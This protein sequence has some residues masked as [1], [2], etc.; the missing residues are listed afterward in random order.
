MRP[1]IP[2]RRKYLEN[3]F[4]NTGHSIFRTSPLLREDAGLYKK[5]VELIDK[6]WGS[7]HHVEIS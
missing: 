5:T 4:P 1:S 3:C 2:E 6:L 7:S